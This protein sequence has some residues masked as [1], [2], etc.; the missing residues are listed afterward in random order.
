GD[1]EESCEALAFVMQFLDVA[2]CEPPLD[3]PGMLGRDVID[4]DGEMAVAVSEVVGFGGALVDRE[5]ELEIG[6]RV[7]EIDEREAVEF[8]PVGDLEAEGLAVKGDRALLVEHPDHGMDDSCHGRIPCLGAIRGMRARGFPRGNCAG[9]WTWPCLHRQ[10]WEARSG[11][12]PR[13]AR[14]Q[15]HALIVEPAAPQPYDHRCDTH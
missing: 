1:E 4:D 6:L 5:F 12:G 2:G 9:R 10:G 8:E 14:R 3:E 11:A 15:S 7:A 13:P